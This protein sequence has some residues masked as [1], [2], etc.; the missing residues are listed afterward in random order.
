MLSSVMDTQALAC[1]TTSEGVKDMLV[2]NVDAWPRSRQDLVDFGNNMIVCLTSWYYRRLAV[3]LIQFLK[4]GF[5][6]R[7]S[8]TPLSLTRI[9]QACGRSCLPSC[10]TKM[11]SKIFFILL[12]SCWFS[13]FQPPNESVPSLLR[14]GSRI[15][16]VLPFDPPHLKI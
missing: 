6:P 12:K 2:F 10:H 15:A 16:Y 1:S 5:H 3:M 8:S 7:S 14:T 11:T 13:Q 4:S 9:I